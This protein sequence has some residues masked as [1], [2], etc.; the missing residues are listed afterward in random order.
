MLFTAVIQVLANFKADNS[1]LVFFVAFAGF[2][3]MYKEFDELLFADFDYLHTECNVHDII[4]DCVKHRMDS[5][6]QAEVPSRDKDLNLD[7]H[8]Y[9]WGYII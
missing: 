1:L 4:I 6:K 5:R 8:S 7:L 2:S 3:R 9:F